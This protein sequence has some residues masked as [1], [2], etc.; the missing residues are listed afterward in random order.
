MDAFPDSR[1]LVGSRLNRAWL[2]GA[3]APLAG[4]R[5]VDVVVCPSIEAVV[6]SLNVV[7][8][9]GQH[10]HGPAGRRPHCASKP[11]VAYV[12]DKFPK[13]GGGGGAV[14]ETLEQGRDISFW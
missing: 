6:P 14:A 10:E 2:L 1:T 5:Q 8:S 12:L 13:T 11:G 7:G 9:N 4:R 3:A